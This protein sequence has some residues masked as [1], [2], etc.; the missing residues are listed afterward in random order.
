[1]DEGKDCRFVFCDISKAF[2][3]V[4]HPGVIFK[5]KRAGITGSLLGWLKSYLQNRTQRVT[6]NG[7]PSKIKSLKAGVPQSSVLGPLLFILYINDL[8]DEVNLDLRIYA[9][10]TTLYLKFEDPWEA[11]RVIESNLEYVQEWARKW[12]I[13]FNPAKT[14]SVTFTRKR[15]PVVPQIFMA[16]TPIVDQQ[17]HKHLGITLQSNGKWGSHIDEI[18]KE[19]SK[20]TSH[21]NKKSLFL[22]IL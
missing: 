11:A 2:D 5:L 4:W 15:E 16:N 6:I 22:S 1:M 12:L 7:C 18:V 21:Y 19:G 20:R 9:D 8:V 3:R 10:D 14:V 17:Q 13:T